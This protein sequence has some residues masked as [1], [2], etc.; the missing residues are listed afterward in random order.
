[1]NIDIRSVVKAS[2][3][4][5]TAALT[6]SI[7]TLIPFFDGIVVVFF[8]IGAFL[9]PV[10]AGLLYGYFAR[11]QEEMGESALGGLLAGGLAG[12]TFGILLGLETLVSEIV[13]GSRLVTIIARSGS[14]LI[15][16][17]CGF[18]ISG[19][20]FGA[21]GGIIWPVLQRNRA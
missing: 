1:M 20:A 5:L 12:L 15:F 16:S 3:V 11:G 13:T 4:T 2:A 6:F 7:L 9:I 8:C 21:I 10:S 18:V 19:L 14:T 17:T